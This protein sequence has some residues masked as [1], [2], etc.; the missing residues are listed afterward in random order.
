M[1]NRMLIVA[2]LTTVLLAGG[3]FAQTVA[4]LEQVDTWKTATGEA[5]GVDDNAKD[6]ATK[7]ALRKAVEQACG[8]FITSQSKTKDYQAIYDKVIV[9]TVGYVLEHKVTKVRIDDGKTIVTVNARVST[10]KFEED[11]ARIAHTVNQENN[12]RVV[13][14]IAEA[15]SW[16][17][18]GPQYEVDGDGVAQTKVED[19]LVKKGLMLM[20]HKM[21]ASVSKRDL[22]LA[23]IKDDAAAVAAAG[24]RFKADVVIVG[25][26]NVKM[27]DKIKVGD[28]ELYQ[29]TA[30]LTVRAIQTDSARIL[31]SKT[32]GPKV[33]NQVQI[34]SEDKAIS[35]LA[36]EAAPAILAALVDAWAKR[37]NVGRTVELQISDM[38]YDAW[39]L[40]KVEADKIRGMQAL[41]LREITEAVAT[42][43]AEYEFT[44]E[45][46]ADRLSGIAQ[47][48][49]K[50][51]EINANRIKLKVVKE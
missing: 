15:T 43:D 32:F 33:F 50:V 51:I 18:K 28:S 27:G 2:A 29:Y 36:D 46:L 8:V 16:T 7:V 21:A 10:K 31:M 19:F 14:A 34:R 38:D 13:V 12:P 42:I 26:A 3:T 5:V 35:K 40:F 6:E 30:V 25:K 1:T 20:D 23:E 48:K 39:K 41:R 9:N 22:L 47:P 17:D 45:N 44:N 49:L 11:W 4:P 37:A 24:T